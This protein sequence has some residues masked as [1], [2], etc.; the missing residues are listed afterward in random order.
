LLIVA[1]AALEDRLERAVV[2]HGP[3]AA[4]GAGERVTVEVRSGEPRQVLADPRLVRQR[5]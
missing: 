5:R 4:V 3:V 1:G 2:A